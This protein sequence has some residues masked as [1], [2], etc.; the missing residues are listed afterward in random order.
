MQRL[1]KGGAGAGRFAQRQAALERITSEEDQS[2]RNVRRFGVRVPERV[3]EAVKADKLD[4]G[5]IDDKVF[6]EKRRG[7]RAVRYR[8]EVAGGMITEW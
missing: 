5:L 7:E 4:N 1:G 2:T 8:R 3:Y 6:G